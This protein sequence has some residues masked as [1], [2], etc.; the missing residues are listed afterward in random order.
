MTVS[1]SGKAVYQDAAGSATP[2]LLDVNVKYVSV[3]RSLTSQV[4]KHHKYADVTSTPT[5]QVRRRHKY[6]NVRPTA[7]VT[8]TPAPSRIRKQD[9]CPQPSAKESLRKTKQ[10][11]NIHIL[12]NMFYSISSTPIASLTSRPQKNNSIIWAYYDIIPTEYATKG[13]LPQSLCRLK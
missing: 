2:Q 8:S 6:A 11:D 1:W 7:N 5:S 13:L 12:F 9:T 3:T 10:N 4:R